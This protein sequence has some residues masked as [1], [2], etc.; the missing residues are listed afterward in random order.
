MKD[1]YG[2]SYADFVERIGYPHWEVA[3]RWLPASVLS[4]FLLYRDFLA[5]SESLS[6]ALLAAIDAELAL[7]EGKP[8]E[9]AAALV[10]AC[11]DGDYG[12]PLRLKKE[13]DKNVIMWRFTDRYGRY[14]DTETFIWPAR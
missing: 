1:A 14:Y 7:R 5:R 11:T 12:A 4:C 2:N 10:S 3:E 9:E 13:A 6:N 8:F